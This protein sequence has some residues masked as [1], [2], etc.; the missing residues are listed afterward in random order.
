MMEGYSIGLN[1]SKIGIVA[2]WW[3]MELMNK[4]TNYRITEKSL[5]L[6][7]LLKSKEALSIGLVDEV[8][9]TKDELYQKCQEEMK[10]W[11]SIPNDARV[12]TKT[13]YRSKFLKVFK[14]IEK[15]DLETSLGFLNDKDSQKKI[16][17]IFKQL[18]LQKKSKL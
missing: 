13:I 12:K 7:L 5:Q 11:L 15:E 14:D 1:E 3:L 4:T 2:P 18:F 6:G 9:Q 10:K 16:E 17:L 8:V